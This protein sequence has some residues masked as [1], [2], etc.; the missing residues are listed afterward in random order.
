M[1]KVIATDLDGTLF[2]PRK[3]LRMISNKSLKFIQKFIDE[4]NRFVLVSGRNIK[5]CRKVQKKINRPLD[6]IGCNGAIIYI[7]DELIKE[8]YFRN[9]D[10]ARI[11]DEIQ[12]DYEPATISIMTSEENYFP[13]RENSFINLTFYR[14][15]SF[16][17]FKYKEPFNKSFRKFQEAFKNGKIYK[18]LFVLGI[19]Q[20]A[21]TVAKEANKTIREKYKDYVESSWSNQAIELSP[22][23]CSKAEGLKYYAD[24]LMINRNDIYVVGDSGNDISMFKEFHDNSF[25]MS[26]SPLSVSKHSKRVIKHFWELE[27]H[28]EERK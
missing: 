5:Y 9:E 15:W 16:F 22:R 27:K 26:R 13:K 10:I 1:P 11:C 19:T 14:L 6:I 4:G 2:Y 25:C 21:K 12:K 23:G 20:R 3:P 18:I 17:E 24:Y 8:S 7:G 28:F